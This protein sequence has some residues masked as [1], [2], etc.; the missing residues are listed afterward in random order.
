VLGY[1]FFVGG[2][3]LISWKPAAS[4]PPAPSVSA[5]VAPAR[6]DSFAAVVDAAKPAVVNIATLQ[7]APG[8]GRSGADSMR[9]LGRAGASRGEPQRRGTSRHW[10]APRPWFSQAGIGE[11]AP[12]IRARICA[13]REWCGLRLDPDRNA[14]AV[15]AEGCISPPDAALTAYVITARE[16]QVIARKTASCVAGLKTSPRS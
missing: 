13:G 12:E 3:N 11:H 14:A 2:Q 10:A 7:A 5:V 15:G 8:R 4:P 6:P 9:G 16:E 1:I